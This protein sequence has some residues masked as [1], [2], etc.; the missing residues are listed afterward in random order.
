MKLCVLS[1]L[2]AIHDYFFGLKPKD[3]KDSGDTDLRSSITLI[4]S[5]YTLNDIFLGKIVK[6]E[7]NEKENCFL[8]ESL[9]SI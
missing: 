2:W 9:G 3:N 5:Y 7:D 8:E 4:D 1:L 6:D